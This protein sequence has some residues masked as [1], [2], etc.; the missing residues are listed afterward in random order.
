MLFVEY[1]NLNTLYHFPGRGH[2]IILGRNTLCTAFK[3][4]FLIKVVSWRLFSHLLSLFCNIDVRLPSLLRLYFKNI[5]C[6][7]TPLGCNFFVLSRLDQCTILDVW[8]GFLIASSRYREA[9][10]SKQ[11]TAVNFK[12]IFGAI[13]CQLT[14]V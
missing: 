4:F 11:V 9:V 3:Y 5:D 2:L 1:T 6:L 8:V 14:H 12:S 7:A 13:G 10:N